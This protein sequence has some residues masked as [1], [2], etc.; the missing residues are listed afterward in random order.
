MLTED[1]ITTNPEF[2][3]KKPPYI[4]GFCSSVILISFIM[5]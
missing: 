3:R 2:V 1:F 4:V 5:Y